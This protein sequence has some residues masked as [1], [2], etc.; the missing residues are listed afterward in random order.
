MK[1][2]AM[3]THEQGIFDT[4]RF[5]KEQLILGLVFSPPSGAPT[6][7]KRLCAWAERIFLAFGEDSVVFLHILQLAHHDFLRDESCLCRTK[8]QIAG[9][10]LSTMMPR[11]HR[12]K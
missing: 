6:L 9:N 11:M 8:R 5:S 1:F 12:V 2:R 7:D 10:K 4:F 3:R